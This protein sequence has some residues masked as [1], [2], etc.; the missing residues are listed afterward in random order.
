MHNCNHFFASTLWLVILDWTRNYIVSA[1]LMQYSFA[2]P[3]KIGLKMPIPSAPSLIHS[4]FL[5]YIVTLIILKL[6]LWYYYEK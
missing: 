4:Y 5:V 1:N 3:L 2:M 6:E